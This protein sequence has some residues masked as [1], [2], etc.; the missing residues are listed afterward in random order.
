MTEKGRNF[1]GCPSSRRGL[2]V[3]MAVFFLLTG[4]LGGVMVG[5]FAKSDYATLSWPST[6]GTIVKSWVGERSEYKN[7]RTHHMYTPRVRYAYRVG[8]SSQSFEG[9]EISSLVTSSGDREWA[10]SVVAS[11]A[12]GTRVTVYYNPDRP[13]EALLER[14]IHTWFIL[15]FV[16][17][18]LLFLG[19]GVGMVRFR[20]AIDGASK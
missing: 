9:E 18:A 7:G 13:Q 19:L 14:G 6:S 3:Q 11:Y 4:V 8:S 1:R 2:A 17:V 5:Y 20:G 12:V 10:D 16:G 15:L